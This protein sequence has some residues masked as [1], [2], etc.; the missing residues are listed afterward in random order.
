MKAS[1]SRDMQLHAEWPFQTGGCLTERKGCVMQ[2]DAERDGQRGKRT[3]GHEGLAVAALGQRREVGVL[4]DLVGHE[5]A[6]RRAAIGFLRAAKVELSEQS[7]CRA[8][9][10]VVMRHRV[11]PTL[12]GG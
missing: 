9:R 6:V 8:E 10:R 3:H 5:L 7:R 2:S 11:R 12:L 1:E 4:P